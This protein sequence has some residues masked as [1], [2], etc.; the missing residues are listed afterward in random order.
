MYILMVKVNKFIFF[1]VSQYFLK[2]IENMFFVFLVYDVII[3]LTVYL[4]ILKKF[5]QVL[6]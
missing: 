5:V 2:G 3:W 1:F 6:N 4:Y